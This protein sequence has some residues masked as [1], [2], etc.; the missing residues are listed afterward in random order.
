MLV[1]RNQMTDFQVFDPYYPEPNRENTQFSLSEYADLLFY[2]LQITYSLHDFPKLQIAFD[3]LLILKIIEQF[4]LYS[5]S[6][7]GK[8][9]DI[10]HQLIFQCNE[11]PVTAIIQQLKELLEI[12][13]SN[14]RSEI[15][16]NLFAK[17]APKSK[18]NKT[19]EDFRKR[20]T[21]ILDVLPKLP[22]L[23]VAA[24]QKQLERIHRVYESN[25]VEA[26]REINLLIQKFQSA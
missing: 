1:E 21:P 7:K 2:K 12:V 15:I 26:D 20:V 18:K 19:I 25:S 24:L 13:R 6:E 16:I 3:Y 4:D 14:S 5:K 8:V 9:K 22:E 17:I 23:E 11:L 10:L